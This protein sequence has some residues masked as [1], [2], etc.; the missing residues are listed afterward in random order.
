MTQCYSLLAFAF[1]AI[2]QLLLCSQP[3]HAYSVSSR[4]ALVRRDGDFDSLLSELKGRSKGSRMR[5]GKRALSPFPNY[6]ES[7][8]SSWGA[9]PSSINYYRPHGFVWLQ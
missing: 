2:S 3:S 6:Q 8:L 1:L 7:G 5:F 9:E 4:I